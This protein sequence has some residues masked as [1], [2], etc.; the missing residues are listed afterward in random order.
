MTTAMSPHPDASDVALLRKKILSLRDELSLERQKNQELE[1]ALWKAAPMMTANAD[2]KSALGQE[3]EKMSIPSKDEEGDESIAPSGYISNMDCGNEVNNNNQKKGHAPDNAKNFSKH[4]K[5]QDNSISRRIYKGSISAGIDR[6]SDNAIEDGKAANFKKI[7]SSPFMLPL[8]QSLR[9]G[10]RPTAIAKSMGQ[11]PQ[12]INYH[13]Q[14]MAS[15]GLISKDNRNKTWRLT[16][17]GEFVLKQK[18]RQSVG[19]A[20]LGPVVARMDNLAYSFQI[21]SMPDRLFKWI[22]MRNDIGRCSISEDGNTLDIIKSPKEWAS[23]LIVHLKPAYYANRVLGQHKGYL[24]AKKIAHRFADRC[25]ITIAEEGNIVGKPH[26]VF[27]PD[28]SS[29]FV[30]SSTVV[31]VILQNGEK[32]WVDTSKGYGELETDGADYE[33]L[34]LMQPLNVNATL[35]EVVQLKKYMIGHNRSIHPVYTDNN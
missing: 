20:T 30:G 12:V 14:E 3:H 10:E 21:K 26:I 23:V 19:M 22:E 17:K 27:D 28:L 34:F 15:V 2:M 11:S 5:E 9:L 18:I 13:I 16:E 4:E 25:N 24:T 1:Q 6:I 29:L 32:A 7:F 8:L 31:E 33:Y 35:E